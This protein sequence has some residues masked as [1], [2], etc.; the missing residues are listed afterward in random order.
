MRSLTKKEKI[1]IKIIS[2]KANEVDKWLSAFSLFVSSNPD[3]LYNISYYTDKIEEFKDVIEF[4]KEIHEVYKMVSE[5][6]YKQHK[7]DITTLNIELIFDEL[8]HST[9]ESGVK[10]EFYQKG[11][12]RFIIDTIKKNPHLFRILIKQDESNIQDFLYLIK[13]EE[14]KK[15]KEKIR[16]HFE[17]TVNI[18]KQSIDK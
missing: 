4:F 10:Y 5:D 13:F 15:F 2:M 1:L 17:K 11:I 3:T 12:E 7:K 14:A 18:I 16:H 9:F 6:L 8:F